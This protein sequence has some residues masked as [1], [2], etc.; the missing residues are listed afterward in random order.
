VEAVALD[1]SVTIGFLDPSDSHHERAVD[2]LRE[3]G[4]AS[5]SMAASAYSETLVKPLAKGYGERVDAFVDDLRVEIVPLD[6]TIAREVAEMRARHRAL[7]LPDAVVVA[8]A[9][10][11][12][13]RL[14]TFD[15]RLSQL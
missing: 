6:R 1:A 14:L 7:R 2:A 8:T 4:G 13:A 15:E 9:Q 10:A 5:L 11:R 12:G 3:C